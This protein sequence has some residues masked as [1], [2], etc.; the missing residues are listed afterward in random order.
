MRRDPATVAAAL[1]ATTPGGRLVVYGV[2]K[3]PLE[4]F[5]LNQI[6]VRDLTVYGALSDR[7]G[8]ETPGIELVRSGKLRLKPLITHRFPLAAAPAA[9][10][11]VRKKSDGVVKAVIVL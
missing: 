5:D 6:V 11:L 2:Q 1:A 8:S 3:A 7:F 9:Y 4:Q 10:D